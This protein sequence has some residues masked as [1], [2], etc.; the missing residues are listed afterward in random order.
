MRLTFAVAVVCG[1]VL[2]MA[3]AFG[4]HAFIKAREQCFCCGGERYPWRHQEQLPEM[5]PA[6]V[7]PGAEAYTAWANEIERRASSN[8][9]C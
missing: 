2:A 5:S 3:L 6:P 8:N 1:F 9:A 7:L 4:G